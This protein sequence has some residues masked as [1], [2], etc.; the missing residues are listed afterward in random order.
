MRHYGDIDLV[1]TLEEYDLFLSLSTHVS[2]VFVP[3]VWTRYRKRLSDLMGFKRPVVEALTWNGS[4]VG[5][6]M[7]FEFLQDWFQLPVFGWLP[8]QFCGFGGTMGV[9]SVS[10]LSGG[11]L[12][13]GAIPFTIRIYQFSH[14]S[15]GVC[16]VSWLFFHSCFTIQD[17]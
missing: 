2:T 17:Y 1:P 15:V 5:R 12:L 10:G 3:L 6:S 8:R 7:S 4:G 13:H 9:L 14:S 11:L 16:S